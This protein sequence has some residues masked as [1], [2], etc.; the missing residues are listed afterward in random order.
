MPRARSPPL[1]AWQGDSPGSPDDAPGCLSSPGRVPRPSPLGRLLRLPAQPWEGAPRAPRRGPLPRKSFREHECGQSRIQRSSGRLLDAC[2][3]RLVLRGPGVGADGMACGMAWA[4]G[5]A[6]ACGRACGMVRGPRRRAGGDGLGGRLLAPP[7]AFRRPRS[8]GSRPPAA[9]AIAGGG[10]RED[11][12]RFFSLTIFCSL[13][14]AAAALGPGAL[15]SCPARPA[16]ATST[17]GMGGARLLP[18]S[19]PLR[20]VPLLGPG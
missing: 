11:E 7:R 9:M 6:L 2:W 19:R 16:A 8:P 1:F 14:Y 10:G 3:V 20:T 18:R 13:F 5:T 12:E 4:R 17:P 15:R